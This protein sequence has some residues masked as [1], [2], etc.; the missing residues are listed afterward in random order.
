M[1]TETYSPPMPRIKRHPL[2]R[3]LDRVGLTQRDFGRQV[4]LTDSEISDVFTGRKRGF[5]VPQAMAVEMASGVPLKQLVGTRE[6]ARI[7][8]LYVKWAS[9]R[10]AYAGT[11]GE[12]A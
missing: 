12:V 8:E 1:N 4:G 6:T 3:Y 2:R 11:N 7:V 5:T 9:E 10:G